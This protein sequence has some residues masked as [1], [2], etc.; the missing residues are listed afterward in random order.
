[1]WLFARCYSFPVLRL[2]LPLLVFLLPCGAAPCRAVAPALLLLV[3]LLPVPA[4]VVPRIV[5]SPSA[6]VPTDVRHCCLVVLVRCNASLLVTSW[7]RF[8]L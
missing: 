4:L 3:V 7:S 2:H 1:M 6:S 8:K 5:V